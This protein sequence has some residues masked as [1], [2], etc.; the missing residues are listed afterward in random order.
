[1][2]ASHEA[3]TLHSPVAHLGS[4]WLTLL[5]RRECLK[6]HGVGE[7]EGELGAD[8]L[9][10]RC[11]DH[12]SNSGGAAHP[13]GA[14]GANVEGQCSCTSLISRAFWPRGVEISFCHTI[15]HC[16]TILYYSKT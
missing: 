13:R 5:A 2:H 7:R 8:L 10:L 14:A 12:L 4:P 15:D 9:L 6:R 3:L 1:M 11:Q 16:R